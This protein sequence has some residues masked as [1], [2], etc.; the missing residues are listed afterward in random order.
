MPSKCKCIKSRVTKKGEIK[1][2]ERTPKGCRLPKN[3][4]AKKTKTKPVVPP[5]PPSP[6]ITADSGTFITTSPASPSPVI[7]SIP[8][9]VSKK[10]TKSRES[11]KKNFNVPIASGTFSTIYIN[12]LDPNWVLRKTEVVKKDVADELIITKG[13]L[14]R[15]GQPSNLND[16]WVEDIQFDPNSSY[17]YSISKRF[18]GDGLVFTDKSKYI[19]NNKLVSKFYSGL[20]KDFQYLHSLGWACYDLK[21]G[22]I[23]IDENRISPDNDDWVRLTDFGADWC[24][25]TN[26]LDGI[27]D[28]E[29]QPLFM[30]IL[31][32]LHGTYHVKFPLEFGKGFIRFMTDLIKTEKSSGDYKKLLKNLQRI[33]DFLLY[34]LVVPS[35]LIGSKY[36]KIQEIFL[37][38][39]CGSSNNFGEDKDVCFTVK[40]MEKY[41]KQIKNKV[42]NKLNLRKNVL[43]IYKSIIRI[44]KQNGILSSQYYNNLM[45]ADLPEVKKDIDLFKFKFK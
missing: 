4:A 43:D 40:T 45:E 13:M 3:W 35:K 27:I 24:K 6:F 39:T 7:P 26:Q 28:S 12:P 25:N 19:K 30:L 17:I 44:L 2:I 29:Y 21:P 37:W 32:Q 11:A 22:N 34:M 5:V 10:D 14:N 41:F 36:K 20:Y 23:L 8:S 33:Y 1:C 9:T 16:I 31:F 38:Y 42:G 15:P 18:S